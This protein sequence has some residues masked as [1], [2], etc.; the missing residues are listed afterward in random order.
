MIKQ[1]SRREKFSIVTGFAAVGLL[2]ALHWVVLPVL[3]QRQRTARQVTVKASE[4]VEMKRLQAEY[5]RLQADSERTIAQLKKRSPE[6]SLFSY[7]DALAGKTGLKKNIVYMKP[8]IVDEADSKRKLSR[9]EI[10][11]KAV[12]LD[13][14]GR[15]IYHV[16]TSPNMISV[17]RLSITQKKQESG[18]LEAV[19]QVET[20]GG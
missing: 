1:L 13:Q 5:Y 2:M 15:F 12:T 11:I 9:V 3:E 7:L 10:K 6:F 16:E 8:T 17:P 20:L 18:F 19:F 14:I 4:L